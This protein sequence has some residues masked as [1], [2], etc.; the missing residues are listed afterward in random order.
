MTKLSTV[1]SRN[2]GTDRAGM[3][4]EFECIMYQY[5]KT[6]GIYPTDVCLAHAIW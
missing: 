1:R 5:T 3:K 4:D 6:P 2:R